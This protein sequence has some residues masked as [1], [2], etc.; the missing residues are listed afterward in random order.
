MSKFNTYGLLQGKDKGSVHEKVVGVKIVG[1][2]PNTGAA[3]PRSSTDLKQL[4]IVGK[5]TPLKND[6][7]KRRSPVNIK[8]TLT[9]LPTMSPHYPSSNDGAMHSNNASLLGYQSPMMTALSGGLSPVQE[10]HGQP[11]RLQGA[12]YYSSM[13][14]SGSHT[15]GHHM[16]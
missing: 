15:I 9:R 7:P 6:P 1:S 3:S 14:H 12:H 2:S 8:P 5:G 10:E 11:V 13:M 16:A 4:G